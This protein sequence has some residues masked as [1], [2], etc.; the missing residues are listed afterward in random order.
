MRLFGHVWTRTK[1]DTLKLRPRLCI[2]T[3]SSQL[4][5]ENQCTSAT[6]AKEMV[7]LSVGDFSN[8]NRAR[9]R[10]GRIR[11]LCRK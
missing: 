3:F 11:N 7:N 9:R 8:K 6:D 4:K 5:T 10:S 1:Q 2:V